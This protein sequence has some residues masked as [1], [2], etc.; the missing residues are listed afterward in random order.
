MAKLSYEKWKVY[1]N[2]FD[3]FTLRLL[4]KLSSQGHF[5]ELKSPVSIGKEANIFTATTKEDKDII[6]KVYRLQT[7]NFNKMYDYIKSDRRFEG[8]KKQRRKVIFNWVTREYQN[9]M[10]AR[11]AGVR[12]P[13]P[14]SVKDHVLLLELIGDKTPA[15]KLKDVVVGKNLEDKLIENMKKLYNNGLVHGDLSEF[16][17]LV[18]NDLPIFIDF[19]QGTTSNDPNYDEY[20]QRDIK[21]IARFLNKSGIDVTEEEL[22]EKVFK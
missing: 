13:T 16:N 8:L 5:E 22:K 11:E 1:G 15:P 4:F 21:N 6:V 20:W 2:V 9:I 17:I 10:K 18:H 3:Q 19:S 12:V 7:C 14:I